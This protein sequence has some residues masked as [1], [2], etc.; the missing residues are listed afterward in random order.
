MMNP[1][2]VYF[3]KG[4]LT[5][6]SHQELAMK[7]KE[8]YTN[9]K[10]SETFLPLGRRIWLYIFAIQVW[11]AAKKGNISIQFVCVFKVSN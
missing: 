10:I 4:S 1:V 8:S 9:E 2:T 7:L 6:V 5:I 3:Q 11:L